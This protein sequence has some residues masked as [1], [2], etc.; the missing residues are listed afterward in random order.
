MSRNI[1]K[2]VSKIAKLIKMDCE[3]WG[4][5]PQ[6]DEAGLYRHVRQML[7]LER[8]PPESAPAKV[9]E[10]HVQL[11]DFGCRTED[12]I[13]SAADWAWTFFHD[14]FAEHPPSGDE[15]GYLCLVIRVLQMRRSHIVERLPPI[16]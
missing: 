5:P 6:I 1:K 11:L 10:E 2:S 8:K 3:E 14:L 4:P 16:S 7:D 9:V 12:E 15:D 13:R